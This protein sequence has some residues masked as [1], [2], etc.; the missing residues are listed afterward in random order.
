MGLLVS[1]YQA[2]P[3]TNNSLS[4]NS[5]SG[6]LQKTFRKSYFYQ[7]QLGSKQEDII[8]DKENPRLG[9]KYS[10]Y[11]DKWEKEKEIV[12]LQVMLCGD[13]RILLELIDKDDYDKM[14]DLEIEKE[15]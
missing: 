6:S 4:I 11:Y 14:F 1:S 15:R 8:F 7:C 5:V 3:I 10:N 12:V 9:I 2:N 13:K